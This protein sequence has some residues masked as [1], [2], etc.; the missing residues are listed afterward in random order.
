MALKWLHKNPFCPWVVA[1]GFRSSMWDFMACR[2]ELC[3][4]SQP[5][6]QRPLWSLLCTDWCCVTMEPIKVI[7]CW[8]KYFPVKLKSQILAAKGPKWLKNQTLYRWSFSYRFEFAAVRPFLCGDAALCNS[9]LFVLLTLTQHHENLSFDVL[10]QTCFLPRR[11]TCSSPS[12]EIIHDLWEMERICTFFTFF[13]AVCLCSSIWIL[14]FLWN[15]NKFDINVQKRALLI[16]WLWY[17]TPV[18]ISVGRKQVWKQT[19]NIQ[20]QMEN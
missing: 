9:S 20:T 4:L 1:D 18:L 7:W 13:D 6:A 5:R 3:L 15:A 12:W 16:L 11:K 8:T 19:N 14:Y 17:Q 10:W 2:C